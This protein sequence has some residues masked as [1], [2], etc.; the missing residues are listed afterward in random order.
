MKFVKGFGYF[1]YDFMVGDSIVLAVG[2]VGALAL[3]YL[4]VVAGAAAA[5]EVVLPVVVIG[6]IFASLF[7]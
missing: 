7:L 5:A 3:T 2:G 6:T 4:V 1:W